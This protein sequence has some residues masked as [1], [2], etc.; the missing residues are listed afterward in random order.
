VHAHTHT[1]THT[2]SNTY[3]H[4]HMCACT[5]THAQTYTHTHTLT[6]HTFTHMCKHTHTHTHTHTHSNSCTY[7]GTHDT[8]M[9][10]IYMLSLECTRMSVRARTHTHIH[11]QSFQW[12]GEFVIICKHRVMEHLCNRAQSSVK[13]LL[14]SSVSELTDVGPN[15]PR[16]ACLQRSFMRCNQRKRSKLQK[17]KKIF[18]SFQ[19][20]HGCCLGKKKPVYK[21]QTLGWTSPGPWGK[22]CLCAYKT[23]D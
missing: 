18:S 21:K 15:Q 3:T 1:H 9:A 5:Y 19:S 7:T 12:R 13:A 20:S 22:H 23:I 11:T 4:I 8:H 16:A 14:I 17:K 6:P 10:Y 2:H